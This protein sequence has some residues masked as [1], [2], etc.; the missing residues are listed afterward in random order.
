MNRSEANIPFALSP[1]PDRAKKNTFC[2]LRVSSA[3]PQG[4]MQAR[5]LIPVFF[6]THLA[7]S[8]TTVLIVP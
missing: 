1:S 5:A 2:V 8:K 6:Y 3:A 7:N 4:G